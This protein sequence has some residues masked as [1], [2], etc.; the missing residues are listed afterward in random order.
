MVATAIVAGVS[1]VVAL[2]SQQL[3]SATI[4][5]NYQYL[6][7]FPWWEA[8]GDFGRAITNLSL[9]SGIVT[10]LV[11]GLVGGA[12]SLVLWWRS[13]RTP[14][15]IARSGVARTF[16]NIRLFNEL[17]LVQNV[18]VGMDHRMSAGFFSALLRLPTFFT[19]RERF[20][21]EALALLEF[22]GLADRAHFAA[23]S[24]PYGFRRRLEVARALAGK[25]KLILLD[26]PAAGMNPAEVVD[27]MALIR[28]V[29]DAGT[30]VVLIEHH[31]RLVMGVSD[32]ILVLQYGKQIAEGTPAEIRGNPS[33]VEAYL[34]TE[35]HG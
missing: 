2:N 16:Q 26:E 19:E 11:G 35:N 6:Q 5:A 9:A 10:A 27:L 29:R 32:R 8:V 21:A 7:P 23:G 13:R 25:P 12:A 15:L 4:D 14:D 1:S 3:W 20:H 22:V 33:C 34:G 24:L 31:M 30:T 28:R 17:S 18:L